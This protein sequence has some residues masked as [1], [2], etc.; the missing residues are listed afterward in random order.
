FVYADGN[1]I[2]NPDGRDYERRLNARGLDLVRAGKLDPRQILVTRKVQNGVTVDAYAFGATGVHQHAQLWSDP[3]ATP[4]VPHASALCFV[5]PIGV[6]ATRVAAQIPPPARALLEGTQ[7]RYPLNIGTASWGAPPVPSTECFEL[8]PALLSRFGQ[9][10]P[11][12][13]IA[14]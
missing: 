6:D 2:W 4:Y 11:S 9:T 12:T 1:V 7:R 14:P 8:T 5:S 13:E 3:T 10:L